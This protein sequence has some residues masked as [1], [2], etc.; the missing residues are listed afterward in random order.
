MLKLKQIFNL[1]IIFGILIS[2]AYKFIILLLL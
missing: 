1:L 2:N